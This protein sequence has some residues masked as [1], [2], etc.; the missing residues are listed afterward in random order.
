MAIDHSKKIDD[1]DEQWSEASSMLQK[2]LLV[3]LLTF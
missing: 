3:S 1:D 2:A